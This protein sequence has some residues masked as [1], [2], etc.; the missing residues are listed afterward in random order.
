LRQA[1]TLVDS[2]TVDNGDGYTRMIDSFARAYRGG[3]PFL[4][5]AADGVHNMRALDAAFRSVVSGARE[6][7]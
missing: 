5:T 2:V 4:G 3:E 1:G 6:I 7:V